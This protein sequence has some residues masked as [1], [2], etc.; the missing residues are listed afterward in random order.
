[1]NKI[2]KY[3]LLDILLIILKKYFNTYIY[4]LYYL[5]LNIDENLTFENPTSYQIISLQF[6]HFLTGDQNT[7]N[8]EKLNLIKIRLLD[9]NYRAYGILVNDKLVYSTF[10]SLKKLGLPISSDIDLNQDEGL[11]ED[12]YCHPNYRGKGL[13]KLMN[14]YRLNELL[15]LGKKKCIAIVMEGNLPA[16]K[17]QQ[18][19]GFRPLGYFYVGKILG[20]SFNTLNKK[21]YDN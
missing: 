12:S 17:V 5:K 3:S 19:Y 14:N 7:F 6:E 1:M 13:H 11:L 16:L 2:F 8:K 20:Y 10:I 15:N 4:K 21:K 9:E 18:S